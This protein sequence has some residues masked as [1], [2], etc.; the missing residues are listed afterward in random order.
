M[1]RHLHSAWLG[2]LAT[3]AF[4]L[5]LAALIGALAGNL[6]MA[7]AL[8]A[9]ITLGWHLWR[10]RRLI[11]HSLSRRRMPS[12][13]G[14]GS[15][16]ALENLIAHNQQQMRARKRRL[17]EML[18]AYRAAADALP[19]AV[20]VVDRNTQRIEWFN[21]AAG[22]LLGLHGH[23]DRGSALVPRLQPMPLA[24]W[25]TAGRHAEPILDATSPADPNIRLHLRLVPYS[26]H[27]WLLV[28]RDVTKL[29]QLERVRRDFV[30][31]VSH[32]LR[33]PLTVVHGYLD[34]MEPE[35][36]PGTGPMLEEMRK[37]SQR[38]TQL[39]EDLLT[40]SRL[41]A[42]SPGELDKVPMVP[43]LATLQREAAALS[44]GRHSISVADDG[45]VDLLGS[46]RELHSA[47]SNLVSNA[48]RYT[49]D[50]G[51]IQICLRRDGNSA[52]LSVRDSGYGIAAQHIPR[53]TERFYRV[54][55]SRSRESGGTGLG[56]SIVKHI[57]G[58]H[59]ARLLIHSEVGSGSEFCC[60][61][62]ASH[63]TVR[64]DC[65]GTTQEP[66]AP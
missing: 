61:F 5:C 12:S 57:L 44:Q 66:A 49:P 22:P 2:T 16:D 15:W 10:L 46:V 40:L 53:L 39:V 47:F 51:S 30:A 32:E 56:L 33:T 41:E 21:Q 63:V 38:M 9:I 20:V 29:L 4:W 35:D 50:G 13:A 14:K 64:S 42:Q 28:G 18:Q 54:S 58:L 11:E 3:S 45:S 26:D 31:N 27:R 52:T 19:D 8:A 43:V 48:V 24:H 25:L 17:L 36:F 55:S 34:M 7:L 65:D 59:N 6:W 1:Q 37:Q 62:E 23:A 60:R